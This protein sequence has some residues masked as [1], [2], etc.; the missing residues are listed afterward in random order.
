MKH[1][2]FDRRTRRFSVLCA[3]AWAL[4]VSAQ[5]GGGVRLVGVG[6]TFP[7]PLYTRWFQDYEKLHPGIEFRYL[8]MGSSQGIQRVTSGDADYGA[9]DAPVSDKQLAQATV[10]VLHIPSV[11]SAVVPIYNIPGINASLRLTPQALAG[12]YL[13]SI[14]DWNDPAISRVNPRIQFPAGRIVVIHTADG[15]GT[16]YIW[17]DYLSKVSPEWKARVG[18]GTSIRWPVGTPAEANGNVVKMVKETPNA[19]GYVELPF[20]LANDLPYAS[21]RNAAGRFVTATLESVTVAA[22][23]AAKGGQGDFR[24]SLT[25]APGPEAYPI[26]SFTWILVPER[27]DDNDKRTAIVQFLRWA[28]TDGQNYC[29]LL[30]YAPL[31][32]EIA[33]KALKA[34]DSISGP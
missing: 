20:A 7:Q 25:N 30:N 5:S 11:V 9:T 10:R 24:V 18:R 29:K 19:I 33:A 2:T 28:L 14:T 26:A 22:A 27:I 34:V 17:S 15:R 32:R 1:R 23:T 4:A 21:V 13:G 31:P 16:T 12:I 8:P 3:L 6:S